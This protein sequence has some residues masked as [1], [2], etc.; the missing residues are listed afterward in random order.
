[1][2]DTPNIF[3][4]KFRQVAYVTNDFERALAVLGEKAGVTRFLKI[5]D[6]EFV[7]A[8]D[9]T[10]TCHIGLAMSGGAEIELIEP[11]GGRVAIYRDVLP[12][13]G[14]ALRFHHLA[15]TL[16]S[17]AALNALKDSFRA[18]DV[19]LPIVGEADEGASYFYA[20]LR[21]PFGYY[22]EYVYGTPAFEA[23]MAAAIPVN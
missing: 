3:G 10:A 18:K 13:T 6:R 4:G 22:L 17:L 1:M 14:F 7:V 21:D 11:V 8:P 19:A 9:A 15:Y 16:P 2:I 23:G 20:D 12:A 5:P